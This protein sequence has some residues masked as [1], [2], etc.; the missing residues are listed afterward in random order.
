MELLEALGYV[1][2]G[3]A[4]T[5]VFMEIAYRIRKKVI[6]RKRGVSRKTLEPATSKIKLPTF[7]TNPFPITAIKGGR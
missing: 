6:V 4:P 3:F 2:L 5:L 1:V 7:A